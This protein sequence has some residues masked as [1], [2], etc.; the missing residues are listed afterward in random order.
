MTDHIVTPLEIHNRARKA[1]AIADVIAAHGGTAA[2][3]AELPRNAQLAAARLAGV[4]PP[5]PPT[6]QTVCAVLAD[7]ERAALEPDPF[8]DLQ[9]GSRPW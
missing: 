9:E 4:N 7:R 2:Q 1:T 5:S 3:A 8:A 6:W